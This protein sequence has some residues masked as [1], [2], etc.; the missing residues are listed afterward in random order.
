MT[1][2]Q[3]RDPA[4]QP[5]PDPAVTAEQIAFDTIN[6]TAAGHVTAGWF[7]GA[8]GYETVILTRLRDWMTAGTV[9]G[10]DHEH[11]TAQL[12]WFAVRGCPVGCDTCV[13]G[14]V[15]ANVTGTPEDGACDICGKP[16][17]IKEQRT[18]IF[19]IG[20]DQAMTIC[21]Y[22]CPGCLA[23]EPAGRPAMQ[24]VTRAR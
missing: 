10:C 19:R 5:G 20:L 6:V 1:S 23:A 14:W 17:G 16:A 13:L 12:F 4:D 15:L 22:V 3:R 18:M 21:Y 24:E 11:S 9:P 8:A 7:D 2:D